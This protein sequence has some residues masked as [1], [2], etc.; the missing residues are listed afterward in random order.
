LVQWDPSGQIAGLFPQTVIPGQLDPTNPTAPAGFVGIN[1]GDRD[2]AGVTNA[3]PQQLLDSSLIPELERWTAFLQGAHEVGGGVE[4]YAE[5]LLSRRE[6]RTNGVRQ[7]WTYLFSYDY[8]YPGAGPGWGDPFSAGW[9]GSAIP[10]PTPITDH[11]D[12]EQVVDYARVVAGLRG[13]FGGPLGEVNWDIYVQGSR[14]DAE[15]NQDVI[16]DDAVRSAQLR[17]DFGLNFG[18]SIDRPG[19]SCVGFNTPISNRP[20]IDVNWLDPDFL[21]GNPSP[22]VRAFLFDN[23]TGATI[24]EQ[25]YLEGTLA[26]EIF[27]LP[28]GNVGAVLG[29][30]V[31]HDEIEDTPGHVTLAGNSWGLTSA[32]ITAGD[33]QTHEVFGELRVPI[34]ADAPL[35]HMLSL[36]LSGRYTDVESYGSDTT[37]RVGVNWALTPEWRL[38]GTFGTSFRAPALFEQFLADQTSFIGQRAIDPCIGWD[39]NPDLPPNVAANCSVDVPPGHS[40]SGASA[41]IITGGGDLEAETSEAW[42]V[43]VIW[44]P[45]FANLSVAV[46][47]FEIEINDEVTQ[48]GAG[49]I[50]F[51]C[52]NSPLFPAEPLCDLFTRGS[53]TTNPIIDTVIDRYIN[54]ATQINRGIDITARYVH[55][56][57]FGDF[58]AQAQATHQ[59]EDLISLVPGISQDNNGR[60]GDPEWVGSFDFR[61]D[62]NDWTLFWGIDWIGPASDEDFASEMNNAGTLKF[63][64][65]TEFTA[66]HDVSFTYHFGDD[67]DLTFG[68]ANISDETPPALTAGGFSGGSAT[69]GVSSFQSHYDFIGRRTFVNIT[70]RF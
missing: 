58:T 11:F 35:V 39:T 56:F 29:F 10:S 32:G 37:Y 12:A 33:D 34:L 5:V 63:V 26:G 46:D 66:Y 70:K 55:E 30:N 36:N 31:R 49:N 16:L 4:A 65:D 7:F 40:G 23:E 17:N 50:V 8:F 54:V 52:Y 64:I 6:S 68:I 22:E 45:A 60:V 21:N 25:V 18:N 57:S 15:Y 42:T 53:T 38:R 24:Y 27:T 43:G 20:C 48:L 1:Q 61:F 41:T 51:G 69:V 28:A 59:L 19:A 62:R 14:S 13:A 9:N 44:R 3:R 2:T 47:Y 67:L